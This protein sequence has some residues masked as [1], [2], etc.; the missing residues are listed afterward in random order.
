MAG[1]PAAGLP[2]ALPHPADACFGTST[3]I[4]PDPRGPRDGQGVPD[5]KVLIE[6][7]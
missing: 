2:N 3:S 4:P 5:P 1:N 6:G 7:L